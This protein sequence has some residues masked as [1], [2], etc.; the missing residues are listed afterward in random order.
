[1]PI[2]LALRRL[3]IIS[4]R[5]TQATGEPLSEKQRANWELNLELWPTVFFQTHLFWAAHTCWVVGLANGAPFPFP[6]NPE[7][8]PGS[9]RLPARLLR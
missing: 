6:P 1:M 8:L 9:R 3:R 7:S 5:P 2:I 4:S